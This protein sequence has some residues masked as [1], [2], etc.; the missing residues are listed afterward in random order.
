[1]TCDADAGCHLTV[2]CGSPSRRTMCPN[3]SVAC[4]RGC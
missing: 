3:G 2:D 4:G 1:V